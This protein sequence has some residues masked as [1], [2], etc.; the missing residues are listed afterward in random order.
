MGMLIRCVSHHV[1]WSDKKRLAGTIQGRTKLLGSLCRMRTP[2]VAPTTYQPLR[3]LEQASGRTI[4]NYRRA[5]CSRLALAVQML[6]YA[7]RFV[8]ATT[9]VLIESDCLVFN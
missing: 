4:Q 8:S 3:S 1:R 2:T 7:L 6:R 5:I 9:A